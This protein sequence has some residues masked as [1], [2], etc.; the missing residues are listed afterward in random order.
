MSEL[1]PPDA[2]LP[3]PDL[4]V[5]PRKPLDALV[6]RLR[7]AERLVCLLDYDGT[8]ASFAGRPE[9]AAPDRDLR[10][11]LATIASRP[12]T[13]VHVVSGRSHT[14]LDRWL[15]D[16]PI[17]L[18]AEHGLWAR[19]SDGGAWEQM[20]EVPV[21]W[22][23]RVREVLEQFV[24]RTPGSFIEEKTASIA[25]HYRMADEEFGQRQAKDLTLHVAQAF[26]NVPVEVLPG[27]KVVEIKPHGV[28]KGLVL[29]RLGAEADGALLMAMGDDQTDEDLFAAMPEGGVT[30]HVGPKP[31]RAS[32]RVGDV[33]AARALL[34]A[35]ADEAA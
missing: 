3:A 9:L 14:V 17:G 18:Q 28:H 30:I 11:L 26:S 2:F 15:G 19:G 23:S 8:L 10:R 31:S 6:G 34:W 16:L 20:R 13:A 35:I 33:K 22:K 7:S 25:W 1:S 27:E 21:D 5:T 24:V 4:R 29:E 32:Y 12:R